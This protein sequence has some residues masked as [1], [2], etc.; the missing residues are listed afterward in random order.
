M[1]EVEDSNRNH[2]TTGKMDWTDSGSISFEIDNALRVNDDLTTLP[3]NDEEKG[4]PGGPVLLR[5]Q[6]AQRGRG[7]HGGLA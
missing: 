5:D 7:V 3:V 6:L 2:G 4:D 1:V